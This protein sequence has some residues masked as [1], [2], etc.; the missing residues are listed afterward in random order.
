MI[1]S[2]IPAPTVAPQASTAPATVVPFVQQS[3]LAR[4]VVHGQPTLESQKS[5]APSKRRKRSDEDQDEGDLL[6]ADGF[7]SGFKRARLRFR[8]G[9]DDPV[10][11]VESRGGRDVEEV[12]LATFAKRAR[13]TGKPRA[14]LVLDAYY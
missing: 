6:A 3:G 10:I 5:E 14:G 4:A 13:E 9:E 11:A 7:A 1:P 8:D 2:A 12:D